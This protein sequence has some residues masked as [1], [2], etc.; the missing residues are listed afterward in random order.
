MA[1]DAKEELLA[2]VD[3]AKALI[4]ELDKLLMYK[5]DDKQ[6][7]KNDVALLVSK[8]LDL[9]VFDLVT[10]VIEKNKKRQ[11]KSIMIYR[12]PMYQLLIYLDFY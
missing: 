7:T 4:S 3:N 6:I 11:L 2:R 12:L 5:Y 8:N 1:N 10:A 9:N